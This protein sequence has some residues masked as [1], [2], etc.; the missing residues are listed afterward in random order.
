[1]PKFDGGFGGL[2]EEVL[3]IGDFWG[4]SLTLDVAEGEIREW[5]SSGRW[6][7]N[8]QLLLGFSDGWAG[9]AGWAA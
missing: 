6:L 8:P 9:W 1:M 2:F 5:G 3:G 4:S 7:K